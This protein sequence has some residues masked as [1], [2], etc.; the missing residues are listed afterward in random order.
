MERLKPGQVADVREPL[1]YL[2]FGRMAD[3]VVSLSAPIPADA[4]SPMAAFRNGP[5][6]PDDIDDAL[7][8]RLAAALDRLQRGEHYPVDDPDRTGRLIRAA[9]G[10]AKIGDAESRDA[11]ARIYLTV[12][13]NDGL[14]DAVLALAQL[15]PLSM[16]VDID[17]R[18]FAQ[19]VEA[20]AYLLIAETVTVVDDGSDANRVHVTAH[21]T[22][23]NVVVEVS[24]DGADPFGPD[25][26]AEL[27]R[28]VEAFDGDL[29]I[30]TQ[31]G[32]GTRVRAVFPRADER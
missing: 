7:R 18:R 27:G 4:W 2:A 17:R 22:G 21:R 15:F 9:L 13:T 5:G 28:R 1:R 31:S 24:F 30:V 29:E 8:R 11:I 23:A 14:V 10:Y 25:R 6:G 3:R 32:I 19:P 12:L 20:A 16:T 26:L